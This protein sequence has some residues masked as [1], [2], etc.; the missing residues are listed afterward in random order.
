[1]HLRNAYC[2]TLASKNFF[3]WRISKENCCNGCWWSPCYWSMENRISKRLMRARNGLLWA[4]RCDPSVTLAIKPF[5]HYEMSRKWDIIFIGSLYHLGGL[6]VRHGYGIPGGYTDTGTTG[7]DTDR[8]FC[9]RGH[10]RTL[11]PQYPPNLYSQWRVA[12]HDT[13]AA[14]YSIYLSI[15]IYFI[16]IHK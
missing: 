9:T 11:I 7:T 5:W 6:S 15:Y 3:D 12:W 2:I 13:S 14:V 8:L 10:T 4:G 1:M 16:S